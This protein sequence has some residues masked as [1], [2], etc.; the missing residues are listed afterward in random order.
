M[1]KMSY[2][3]EQQ[4][5]FFVDINEFFGKEIVTTEEIKMFLQKKKL[6]TPYFFFRDENRKVSRGKYSI[7]MSVVSAIKPLPP[8]PPMRKMTKP[9]AP[10]F[11]EQ[12]RT[13][14]HGGPT[15]MQADISC[16]VPSKDPTYVP[17]GNYSDIEK[18]IGS[19]IF[20]PVYVTGLSGNGKTMSIV[21]ACAKLKREILRINVTEET[22]E[23]DLIGGTELV[24]GTTVNREGAVLLA[25]RRGAVLLIDEGDL[26]NTKILCLMP[27]LEGKP[28][29]NKKTGE[30]IH[31]AEGFNVFITG[32]TKG[33]GSDDGRFV[34]T[35]VMNEAFLERFSITMEQEYPTP[36]IEKKIVVKNMEQLGCVD[37]D[38][39][40]KLCTWSD[41]IRKAFYDG[42]VDEIIS[43]RRLVHIVKTFSIFSDRLKAVN[44]ALNRFDT[45]TKT[46]F[47]DFYTKCDASV[48]PPQPETVPTDQV[49]AD[50][51]ANT[52]V[53]STDPHTGNVIIESHGYRTVIDQA[54]IMTSSLTQEEIVQRL[55]SHHGALSTNPSIVQ[56]PNTVKISPEVDTSPY[57]FIPVQP[58]VNT[59]G[60]TGAVGSE[61][62]FNNRTP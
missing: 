43:T 20:F 55:V 61:F 51:A 44:L 16:T 40:T 59:L 13:V 19:K 53:T 22:D 18:I 26:N 56:A 21:Q 50:A 4:K 7:A 41:I 46:A 38:F 24:D 25:M 39:A 28:Y 45:E 49:A 14:I 23:L 30:V 3:V 8:F 5:Q 27:I 54:D 48:N 62:D 32:N 11:V 37:D 29:F 52:V 9:S 12:E 58:N 57:G 47:L 6:S 35:K 17:F 42:Y 2:S 36:S 33:K 60:A 34:G 15:S 10:A 1:A 31:P